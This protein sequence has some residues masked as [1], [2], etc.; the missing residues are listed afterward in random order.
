MKDRVTA[1]AERQVI[2]ER[3][4]DVVAAIERHGG[5]QRHLVGPSA[6]Y[7]GGGEF[8]FAIHHA[9]LKER[10]GNGVNITR[11][12]GAS[13]GGRTRCRIRDR[14]AGEWSLRCSAVVPKERIAAVILA[15]IRALRRD[16]SRA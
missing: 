15:Q 9:Q 7:S 8:A 13:G 3:A 1:R 5:G 14:T 6:I 10:A 4:N 12:G 11:Y 16:E 2:A